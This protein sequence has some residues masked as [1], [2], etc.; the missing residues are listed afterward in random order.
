MER[1]IQEVARAAGT[2][3]RALRHYHHLG[4]VTPSR[5]AATGT[6]Y[7]DERA[8]VR[9]QR[10]LLLRELGLGLG[11]IA[12]VLSA[13]D[14]QAAADSDPAAAEARILG[15]HLELLRAERERVSTQIG[16]VERTIAALVRAGAAPHHT[17]GDLM[18][19]NM[20][21]GFDHA[22]HRT[23][24]AERWGEPA[25]AASERWWSDLAPDERGDWEARVAALNADWSAAAAAGADPDGPEARALA[26]RHVAWLCS[27][28]GT[29]AHAPGG[30]LAGCL[31]GLGEMYVADERFAANYGGQLGATLV[32]D[33]LAAY[34]AR[35]L[36]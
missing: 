30:D 36:G 19:E 12:E 8:L 21:A 20:F 14:A 17:E 11:A 10:V 7:Y 15:T 16:A 6:R 25:A 31:R 35:E 29:P 22:R 5:V 13:Q 33:A 32:R 3:S 9:I 4:L 18:S 24:V 23:E 26:E 27:V 34:V 1:S 2:T 28:P